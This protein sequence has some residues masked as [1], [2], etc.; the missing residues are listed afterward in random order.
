MDPTVFDE[1]VASVRH[2]NR[3]YTQKIGVLDAS[4]LQSQFSLAE[5]RVLYELAHRDRPT[6]SEIAREL[7]LDPGY[8]SRMLRGFRRRG[9]IDGQPA[10]AD[11]R[12]RHL[13]LT[14]AGQAAFAPLDARSRE[15][16]GGVIG[17]LA[18]TA[19]ARLV[20]AM[21]TIE[22]LLTPA[23]A[24]AEPF[25]LR[26]HRPG[27]MGWI[28]ARH[29]ALYAEEY[30]W[31]QEFEAMVAAIVA[32]FLANL[33]TEHERCWIADRDSKP[34]GSVALVRE[35]DSTAR[36]R[37][38]L[39]EPPARG[40]GLGRRLVAECLG[41]ARQADYRKIILSTFN[42]MVAAR[43]IY[44]ASGFELIDEAPQRRFGHDLVEETWELD[45]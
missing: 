38:L 1:R 21:Q 36:L 12:R 6:A 15:E 11:G 34:V 41:F 30:G 4:L 40:S 22:K 7:R 9:L 45:L 37:L 26:P 31:N 10:N 8:L 43:R 44:Q 5:A 3:F 14:T 19:Q 23:A 35:T 16:I 28:V 29:G 2:F 33:D 32:A 42:V 39:V 24:P 25:A 27:D 20:G 18:D 17:N 13:S